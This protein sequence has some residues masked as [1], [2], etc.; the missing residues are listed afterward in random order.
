MD[1]LLP[2]FILVTTSIGYGLASMRI[3]Q[4]GQEALV[5]RLGQYHRKL[6]PGLNF[7][8]PIIDSIPVKATIRER[9]LSIEPQNAITKDNVSLQA[10]AVIYW[11]IVDLEKT[12]Y[13]VDDIEEAIKNMVLT[14]LRSALGQL[15]LEETYASRKDINQFLLQELDDATANWGVKVTRVEVRDIKPAQTVMESLEQERAA[16]SKKR[17]VLLETEGVVASITKLLEVLERQPNGQTVLQFLI[18]QRYVEANEKLG[19]SPSSKV[20]FMDPK[21]LNHALTDLMGQN[22]DPQVIEQFQEKINSGQ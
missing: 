22:I 16:E 12:F 9:V 5:E 14:T 4:E 18:A 13:A 11:Q 20:V 10:D 19:S 7:I 1:F 15:A 17:A 3:I 21:A 6:E 8:I 2:I